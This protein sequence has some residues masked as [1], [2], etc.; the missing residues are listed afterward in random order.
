[1][2]LILIKAGNHNGKNYMAYT[3]YV[4]KAGKEDLSYVARITLDSCSKGAENAVRVAVWQNGKRTV[5][6][7][8]AAVEKTRKTVRISCQMML[9]ASIMKIT[10]WLEM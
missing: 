3:Y 8:P 4:R 1:M 2:I 5:Y 10:F 6:A 7:E 9:Y